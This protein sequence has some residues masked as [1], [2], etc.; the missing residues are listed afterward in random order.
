MHRT[1]GHLRAAPP[2]GFSSSVALRTC[3]ITGR[4]EHHCYLSGYFGVCLQ[5]VLVCVF[6]VA[7]GR[8]R[9]WTWMFV[10]VCALSTE[11]ICQIKKTADCTISSSLQANQHVAKPFHT[12]R[13]F[14]CYL[15]KICQ[16]VESQ[17]LI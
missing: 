11:K 2:Q 16:D 7:G 12:S 6:A 8:L 13:C 17:K 4:T 3:S 15:N 10:Y 1:T 5:R 9:M 14:D